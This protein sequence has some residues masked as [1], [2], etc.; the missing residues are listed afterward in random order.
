MLRPLLAESLRFRVSIGCDSKHHW[1][2][3]LMPRH[4][5]NPYYVLLAE[6]GVYAAA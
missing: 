2:C 4:A 3:V 6:Q 1:L 5:W